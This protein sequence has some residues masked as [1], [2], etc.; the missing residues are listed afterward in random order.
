MNASIALR[1]AL[2]TFVELDHQRCER[3]VE[4]FNMEYAKIGATQQFTGGKYK[5]KT[6]QQVYDCDPGYLIWVKNDPNS[7]KYNG[8]LVRAIERLP[9]LE[10]WEPA[11]FNPDAPLTFG[12]FKGC[13]M[14]DIVQKEPG[15]IQWLS[16]NARD[17][18]LQDAA[19]V[20]LQQW[21]RD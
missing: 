10:Q 7:R 20:V 18:G 3:I 6:I 9:G 12:K 15:Y 17:A 21:K 11:A 16:E 2:E 14:A 19:R 5:D 4:V 8:A 1:K 13:I